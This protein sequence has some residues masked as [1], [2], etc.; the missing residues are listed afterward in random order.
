VD[1]S[2]CRSGVDSRGNFYDNAAVESFFSSLKKERIRRRTCYMRQQARA[3][4]FDYIEVF[5]NQ[6]RRH[7]HLGQMSR[8]DYEQALIAG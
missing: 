1:I 5:H 7:E 3:D 4:I 8:V 2:S 6:K